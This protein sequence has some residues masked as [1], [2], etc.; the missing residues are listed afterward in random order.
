MTDPI[1]D[2]L[3]RIRNALTVRKETVEVPASNMKRE[4]A[5]ILLE[6]GY[7]KDVKEVEDGYNGKLVL[8]LKYTADGKSVIGG[9]QRVS[10]PGLRAYSGAA[11]MPKVLGGFGI[12]IVSTNKGIMTDEQAKAANVGGE[13]LCYVY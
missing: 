6:E 8:T 13:V 4:I 11:N 7:V 2:M 9:L 5:R 10:K 12:A 1:A 3:T